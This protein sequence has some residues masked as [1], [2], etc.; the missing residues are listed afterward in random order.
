MY[1]IQAG[2]IEISKLGGGG[3]SVV[4]RL[5]PGEFFGEM[6]VILGERRTAQAVALCETRLLARDGQTVEAMGVQRVQIASSSVVMEM[7]SLMNPRM[8]PT[9]IEITIATAMTESAIGIRNQCFFSWP[10]QS[11]CNIW[12]DSSRRPKE[13]IRLFS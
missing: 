1:V 11:R 2:E 6:G 10:A 9:M 8:K 13:R 5:G 7:A 12:R 4:A 3:R